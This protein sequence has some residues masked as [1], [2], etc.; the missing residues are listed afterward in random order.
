MSYLKVISDILLIKQSTYICPIV[1]IKL[2]YLLLLISKLCISD[3]SNFLLS[4]YKFSL[5]K[6]S[7]SEAENIIL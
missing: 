7:L 2:R 1:I 5:L 3:I 4:K 6:T